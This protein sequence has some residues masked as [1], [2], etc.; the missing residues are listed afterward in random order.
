M[1]L[2]F[3]DIPITTV[4][5]KT[6]NQ[7]ALAIAGNPIITQKSKHI[8]IQYHFLKQ[9]V[10]DKSV[11]FSYCPTQLMIAD[12]LTKPL[13]KLAFLKFRETLGLA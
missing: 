12:G 3:F 5:M 8:D 13:P 7:A 6:D 10:A 4:D 11:Q 2:D 9:K 1:L